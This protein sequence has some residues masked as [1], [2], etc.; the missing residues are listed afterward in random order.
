MAILWS[1]FNGLDSFAGRFLPKGKS[2]LSS[3]ILKFGT[4]R[5]FMKGGS[6]YGKWN[7][8]VV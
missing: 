4:K 1:I 3:G 8:K 7:C 5:I 2:I 6:H